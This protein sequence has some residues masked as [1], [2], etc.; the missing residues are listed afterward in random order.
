MLG[1]SKPWFVD[2]YDFNKEKGHLNIFINLKGN[3]ILTCPECKN[4]CPG[5]DSKPRKW[6]HLDSFQYQ[7]FIH[8]EIPRCNC[9][10]HGVKQI[11]IPWAGENSRITSLF[12]RLVIDWLKTTSQNDVAKQMGLSWK[13]VHS[14]Y[15]LA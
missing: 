12:E 13:E 11:E 9:P 10:E 14:V 1:I 6:R 3:I 4:S 8:A 15:Y 5:Y 7:T 2:D